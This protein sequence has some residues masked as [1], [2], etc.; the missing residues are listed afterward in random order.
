MSA[1]AAPASRSGERPPLVAT[2]SRVAS[3]SWLGVAIAAA[4]A[5]ICFGA[6]ANPISIGGSYTGPGLGSTTA[7]ELAL[8]LGG[9]ILVALAS[10]LETRG[11][12]QVLGVGAAIAL[13]ALAAFTALSVDWSLAPSNSWLEA[14]RTL[15][16]AA[17]FAGA[18][19][20][21]A[22][23]ADR[24]RSVIAGVLTA[25]LAVC[26]YGL[27]SKIFPA[28]LDA[29]G[30]S[31][32]FAR[33]Q[34]PF[35][36]WN[37]VGLTAALGIAPCLWL[38]AR[39]EAHGVL[40]ALAA[41]ALC[42]LL[43][44]LL[45]AYSRGAVLAAV[46]GTAV[47]FA[48]VPLR[49]RGLALLAIAGVP[50]AAVF[51]WTLRQPALSDDHVALAPRIGPGHTLGLLLLAAVALSFAAALALRFASDRH[52]LGASR[53]RILSIAVAV[54]L[55][56]VPVAGVAALAHS[57]RGLVG[58]I[59]HGWHQLTTANGAQPGNGANRLTSGGSQQ[60]LYWSYAIKVFNT[61]PSVGAGAGA[62]PVADQ[63]FMTGPALAVNAH[64]YVFQTLADLG[65]A[66][67]ALSLVLAALWLAAAVRS[68][69][70][71]RAR[72]PGAS[73]PE[74]IGLLTMAAVVVTFVVH[75]AVDWTWFVPGDAVIAVLCAGWVAGRG[76]VADRVPRARI[77]LHR[78]AHSPPAAAAA[79]V[80]IALALVVAWSQWQP[81]RS[82]QA[83]NA[84]IDALGNS[85][86]KHAIADETTAV[87]RDGLDLAPQTELAYAYAQ[88][89]RYQLAQRM[90]EQ[91]VAQ[92]PSNAASWDALFQYDIAYEHLLPHAR[93][94]AEHA[95]AQER[96]LNP[97]DPGRQ[98]L[99]RQFI[100]TLK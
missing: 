11:R 17:A 66:G 6:Q 94:I 77:S 73:A 61:N 28:S 40:A 90:L 27:A 80:A 16:Y 99:L 30:P 44:V 87:A 88:D 70:P 62:Y 72:A 8:T 56:L 65:I 69:G 50:A 81:L 84:G 2:I 12:I 24:W 18:I 86:V 68:T 42:V 3:Q 79:A 52:P 26:V 78:L 13:F 100:A 92:Q 19:A 64:G 89:G 39:R 63:R 35:Y 10:A 93:S 95:L 48:F 7:V 29:V 60:A 67:L 45:L 15:S 38:G 59:S 20:L 1:H 76:P 43:I 9:G 75:S 57:S 5:A 54:M 97:Q 71:F 32:E 41:P 14:N 51:A 96:Y 23:A 37:A 22:L 46:I 83:Y 53:R 34:I 58:E 21:V 4:V 25:T 47:W 33:L 91:S 36:Y 31:A 74:R 55:A 85:Q 98:T 82:E 49:L